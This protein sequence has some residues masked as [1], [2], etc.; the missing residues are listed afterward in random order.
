MIS[1]RQSGEGCL[2]VIDK[3]QIEASE[4]LSRKGKLERLA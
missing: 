2:R 1:K 4:K 3:D